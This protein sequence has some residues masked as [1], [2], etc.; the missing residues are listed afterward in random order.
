MDKT[1]NEAKMEIES[2]LVKRSGEL[3]IKPSEYR[4]ENLIDN[5]SQQME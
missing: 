4:V 1:V 5:Q 3:G 2:F